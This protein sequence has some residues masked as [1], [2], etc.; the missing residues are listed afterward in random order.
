LNVLENKVANLGNGVQTTNSSYA[1]PTRSINNKSNPVEDAEFKK[2][3]SEDFKLVQSWQTVLDELQKV[4]PG[5]HG[6]LNGSC[7]HVCGKYVLITSRSETFL[8]L[9]KYND[10]ASL[11][12]GIVNKVLG[13]KFV[14]KARYLKPNNPSINN[15]NSTQNLGSNGFGDLVQR[16][17][18]NGIPTQKVD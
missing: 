6:T 18:D 4:S 12:G 16:A 1:K 8:S 17:I 11:L 14:L 13:G 15:S 5:V 9:F 2:L 7:A 10:N 3:K